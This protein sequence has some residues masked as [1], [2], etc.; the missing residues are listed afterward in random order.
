MMMI[1]V[2]VVF[3]VLKGVVDVDD[4]GLEKKK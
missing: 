1:Y 2:V 4:V 3:V